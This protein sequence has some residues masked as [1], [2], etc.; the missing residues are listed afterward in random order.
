MEQAKFVHSDGWSLLPIFR[1]R[2]FKNLSF[3]KFI[4]KWGK[5]ALQC[6]VGFCC[7]AMQISQNYTYI[8]SL[9]ISEL[10]FSTEIFSKK[11]KIYMI[12]RE[13]RV[14]LVFNRYLIGDLAREFMALELWKYQIA[15]CFLKSLSI[16]FSSPKVALANNYLFECL[17]FKDISSIFQG[18][19]NCRFYLRRKS[20][21]YLPVSRNPR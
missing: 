21:T 10:F 18:I 13:T 20:G 5:I 11:W 12:G 14:L 17:Y 15:F 9:L 19:R 6:C 7:T 2:L 1:G 4:F 16:F 8:I 3:I